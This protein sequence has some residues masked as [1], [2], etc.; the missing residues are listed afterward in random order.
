VPNILLGTLAGVLF[1][2]AARDKFLAPPE[3][4]LAWIARWRTRL[5]AW[6][7]GTPR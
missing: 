7:P 4:L 3:F 6:R 1:K 5:A 2:R